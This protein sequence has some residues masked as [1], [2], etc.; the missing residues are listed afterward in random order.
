LIPFLPQYC[1]SLSLKHPV[2]CPYHDL[3]ALFLI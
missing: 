3:S 2:L 1:L